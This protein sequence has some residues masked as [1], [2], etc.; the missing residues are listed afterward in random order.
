MIFCLKCYDLQYATGWRTFTLRLH[1]LFFLVSGCE[2]ITWTPRQTKSDPAPPL[3]VSI[4][5]AAANAAAIAADSFDDFESL[6]GLEPGK[7]FYVQS[8]FRLNLGKKLFG[9]TF[10]MSKKFQGIVI[11]S[12]IAS[13]DT[14]FITPW[15]S[16]ACPN[17][18]HTWKLTYS[19]DRKN[20]R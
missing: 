13:I 15:T 2:P 14:K 20:S 5:Q 3:P 17:P 11:V 9:V 16:F 4:V 6:A 18:W 19:V 12:K 10:E 8:V 7:N 1:H